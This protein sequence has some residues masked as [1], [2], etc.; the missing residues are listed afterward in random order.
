MLIYTRQNTNIYVYSSSV[1]LIVI[2]VSPCMYSNVHIL[3]AIL[4]CYVLYNVNPSLLCY[5]F[6]TTNSIHCKKRA[7]YS[8]HY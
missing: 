3:F 7:Y 5:M 6:T 4:I 2:H 8:R 1:R